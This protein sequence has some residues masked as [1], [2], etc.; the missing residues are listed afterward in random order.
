M[1]NQLQLA[2]TSPTTPFSSLFDSQKEILNSQIYQL[3]NIIVQQCN[4]TGVNPLSQEMA[5]G[6]L[7]I[8]IGKRPRDLLNPKAIK[9]MQSIFSVKDA[10]NKKEMREISA[11]FGV[12]VTQVRDFFTAQRTRVR[13]FLRLSR[14]KPI[15]TNISIEGPCLIPLSS[16]PSS[17]TEP[18]PLDSAVPTCTEEGPSYLTQDEVLTAIEERDRHF[19]D[20]ILTLMCKE[21]TF[22]GRVKL[23]DWILEVQNPSVLYWF[24]TKGGVMILSAWLSEAAGEEQTSVLHLI[25][26]VLC[27]LPLHK[28][29]P[30]HMSAIL[31]SVNSLR[32]YRTPDISDRASIL[33]ARWSNI[34]AKSQA[35]KKRNGVK[36]ASDMH[37]ELL[38]QQSISEVVGNEVWNSKIEDVEEAR[39]N[40]CGTSENSRNLDSPHPVKLLMAS[41]DDSNKRLKGA[42][43]TKTRERRKVQLMEQPSQRTTGRSLGRPAPATQGR[44]LSADDIQKAKMREQF[45]QSKYG[46]TNNDE[47]SWVK[48]Q[49]PNGITSSPNG[50]LLGAPKLQD[51]P[52]VEECEK[53]NSVASKGTSQL[54]NHLKLSFD[55][56]EPPSKRCKKMQIP[57]R[58]PPGLQLSYA[59]KVCAGG[60]S[61]EVDVQNRRVRRETEAIYRTVQEI[62][63]NPK[64]PWD[65]EM[66]PDDTLTTELPL[67]QLPDAEGAETG[68]LPQEDRKT[69]A[70]AL[71][72]TSN[73][74]ATTAKPDLEL[75][76]ILLKHPGLVYDLTSGQGGNLPSE[77]IVKLLDSIKANERNSLSIQT[78]LARDAEKKVEVPLPSLTLSSDPGTSGL[79]MQNFVKNPFSQ[80]SSMVVPEANDVPQHAVLVHSQETHQASSLVHQQMPLVPQLAQQLAL[81]QAAAGAYGVPQHAPLVHSQE[82]HQ[83]SS[84]VHQQMPLAPQLAQQLALLQAAAG[85][86]GVPQHAPLVHSQEIHQASSFVH[87]QMPLAPQLAQQSALLQ[88]AAGSYGNDHRPSPLNPS[89]NQTVLANPMHSQLSAASE[90]AV[91]RNN[92]SFSGLAEYNQQSATAAARIQGV[93]YG[94]I[95]S[96]QMP[97][98]NIQQ[99]TISLHAPQMS[100][101]RPQLQT[102]RQPAYAPEHM[103]GTIPGSALNRGYPE[104]AIPNHYNPHV[105]GHVEPGLQ[106]AAWRGN[107]N[108]GEGAGF[109]SW[110]LDNRPVRRQEQVARWN[111]AEPQMNMRDRYRPD[112]SAS[113]DPGHYS[114]YRGRADGASRRRGDRRRRR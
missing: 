6:S 110:S 57:W 26:K 94:N 51:W 97:I 112:W 107:N 46:K 86:Y 95:R 42:L 44:P 61:K 64:E 81:L 56:E 41:S 23:M 30:G 85:A 29:F 82:I 1:E 28:A 76:A 83:A 90:S 59:W 5:A 102:Q 89:I 67:V 80:R 50:I 84:F 27:H 62:P 55:V 93:T 31:Q 35:M 32:F 22:S 52:K 72:S 88:E 48:P 47:S 15:I 18:V 49:A 69:E 70:A 100:P 58:K 91:N 63:L 2:L 111:Y 74:I 114:G 60:E 109:E 43:V 101:Q 78:S 37:D 36:S 14:E 71:A 9:Y 54:E 77:Q 34:F 98:A 53:L 11:L 106:Q 73:G 21:E 99:R 65:P 16:D 39:A 75:L 96:S 7:S 108:Y 8:K 66:E 103:W 68:V 24:L 113:R 33:L 13:K 105:A 92:Y 87:Q 17:Q 20:N 38:L 79:S 25:L 4:L 45:M 10:I 104:N 40:L 19:V 3:Q 12:T